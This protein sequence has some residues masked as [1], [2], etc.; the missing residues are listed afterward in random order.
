MINVTP[1]AVER[2]RKV[3]LV[4]DAAALHIGVRGGGCSGLSYV[5]EPTK[6]I[7]D[8]DVV[9]EVDGVK[10]AVNK[11]SM[12][13]VDGMTLDYEGRNLMHL[14]FKIVNPNAKNTCGCGTSFEI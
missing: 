13:Y 3:L 2:A 12:V 11:R 7:L 4:Q 6:V 5:I 14:G 9:F 10:F 1:F 8:T